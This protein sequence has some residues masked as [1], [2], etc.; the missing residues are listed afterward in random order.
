VSV[1]IGQE[2]ERLLPV[3]DQML[4]GG[5]IVVEEGHVVRYLHEPTG[6]KGEKS[7]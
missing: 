5:L 6:V 3:L 2:E 7:R 1:R 4:G